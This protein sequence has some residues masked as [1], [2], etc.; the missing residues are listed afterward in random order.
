MTRVSFAELVWAHHKRQQELERLEE[1]EGDQLGQA[2]G[3]PWE[4]E[5][6]RRLAAFINVAG[7]VGT[8]EART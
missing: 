4:Q 7:G 2:L 5:Y 1:L 8:A 3:G 6:R